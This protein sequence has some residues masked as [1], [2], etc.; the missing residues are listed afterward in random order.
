MYFNYIEQS[1]LTAGSIKL[2]GLFGLVRPSTIITTMILKALIMPN[3]LEYERCLTGRN[4][5]GVKMKNEIIRVSNIVHP[6]N[7]ESM[8]SPNNT[9]NA[10]LDKKD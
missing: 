8:P 7:K 6:G 2:P 4:S 5:I 1:V 3:R 9:T 10:T